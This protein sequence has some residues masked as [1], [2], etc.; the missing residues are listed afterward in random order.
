MGVGADTG[1]GVGLQDT[2]DLTREDHAGEVLDVDLVHDA[3]A[4]GDDLE[5]VEGGLAPAEE[6]VALLVALVLDVDVLGE[7]L[8]GAEVLH[9]DGVVD[10]HLGRGERVDLGRVATEVGD[11][12]AHRGQVD[13]TGHAG[14]VLHDH[15]GRSE[16]DLLARLGRRIPGRERLDVAGGDVRTVLGTEQ[17]LQQDL[18]GVREVL[19]ALDRIQ[20]EDLV[21][22]AVDLQAG[23]GTQAVDAHEYSSLDSFLLTSRYHGF[24]CSDDPTT[25]PRHAQP[26]TQHHL[27]DHVPRL[28]IITS[29]R[30]SR[31]PYRHGPTRRMT[32]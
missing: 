23:L 17:V 3:G 30:P 21:V 24:P 1:V 25:S 8:R 10:H 31:L 19:G 7:G 15:A 16:L 26:A 28:P 11:R 22:R 14:E 6:L 9:D 4:R 20:A 32:A 18:E 27:R 13:D 29:R 5:V 2:V 12:L